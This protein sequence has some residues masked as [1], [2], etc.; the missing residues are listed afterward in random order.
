MVGGSS[1]GAQAVA[2]AVI[3]KLSGDGVLLMYDSTTSMEPVLQA[4]QDVCRNPR[5]FLVVCD[6]AAPPISGLIRS[7]ALEGGLERTTLL[8]LDL[9]ANGAAQRVVEESANAARFLEAAFV[10]GQRFEPT[11]RFLAPDAAKHTPFAPEDNL[12]VLG[13]GKGIAAECAFELARRYGCSLALVGRSSPVPGSE[14]HSNLNRLANFG[15]RFRYQRADVTDPTELSS[16]VDAVQADLGPITAVLHAAG[17]NEPKALATLT[18]ADIEL[19]LRPKLAPLELLEHSLD[20]HQLKALIAFGSI[21][22]RIGFHGEAHYAHANELL[23]ENMEQLSTIYQAVSY[24][25]L[26]LPTTERV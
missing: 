7:V 20:F 1:P 4:A 8:R 14:L 11:L 5:P 21:I 22:A 3:G 26:T 25:H 9:A 13:G 6:A 23:R 18:T 12:L 24:T 15:I 19:T 10:D 16:T 2:N 17:L